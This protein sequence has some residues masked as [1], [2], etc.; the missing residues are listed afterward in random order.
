[1]Y[2]QDNE[3]FTADFWS[4]I[5]V[6]E[7]DYAPSLVQ[8]EYVQSL[9]KKKP[10]PYLTLS[11]M[12]QEYFRYD[13]R[14]KQIQKKAAS[15]AKQIVEFIVLPKADEKIK[16]K[17]IQNYINEYFKSPE[18]AAAGEQFNPEE[19]AKIVLKRVKSLRQFS[20][21]EF[22][23]FYDHVINKSKLRSADLKKLAKS[24]VEQFNQ[25]K[26]RILI[27]QRLEGVLR[28]LRTKFYA[29]AGQSEVEGTN[30]EFIKG[31]LL[32]DLVSEL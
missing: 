22:Y 30:R 32:L 18:K 6:V 12:I 25:I 13:S 23:D 19:A 8:A 11:E 27:I 21:I 4:R 16:R 26:I 7:Y 3:P 14:P 10:K 1:M 31:V 5:E 28:Y 20:L 9:F 17:N 15:Y 29:T 24:D 2:R